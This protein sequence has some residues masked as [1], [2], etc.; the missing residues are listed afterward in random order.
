ML[1]RWKN[2]ELN[3]FLLA[4]KKRSK[5]I[6]LVELLAVNENDV[7]N[8]IRLQKCKD[9]NK[10]LEIWE[11]KL[12]EECFELRHPEHSA[13]LTQ[14]VYSIQFGMANFVIMLDKEKQ[15]PW[16]FAQC[17][18]MIDL[19]V[20]KE[21][22]YKTSKSN[23]NAIKPHIE[24]LASLYF[25]KNVHAKQYGFLLSQIRPY[26]YFYDH[27]KNY[28]A[29]PKNE[30]P[31]FGKKSFFYPKP[32]SRK[33][34]DEC[35]WLFPATVGGNQ[36]KAGAATYYNKRMEEYV[37]LSAVGTQPRKSRIDKSN[38]TL[39]YG[40]TGQKRQWLQ[41]EEAIANIAKELQPH[42]KKIE[43]LIDGMTAPEGNE[44][45]NL[46]DESVYHNIEKS[47]E[48][49][50]SVRSVIGL[51]YRQKIA[52][53]FKVD[54]FIANAGTGCIVPLRFC[55]KSGVLHSNS[56]LN[57]FPG[58]YSET[59][60]I[61]DKKYVKDVPDQDSPRPDLASYHIPWQHIFNL[62]AAVLNK[63]KGMTIPLVKVPKVEL[64]IEG[65][66]KSCKLN[67]KTLII[68]DEFEIIV[69]GE[70]TADTL[71]DAAIQQ[72]RQGNV[73]AALLIMLEAKKMRPKGPMINKKIEQYRSKI[74]LD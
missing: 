33:K 46:E 73:E 70:V 71:R 50:C 9:I 66:N 67:K 14:A 42:F 28:I 57:S 52:Q 16:L 38:L 3:R 45:E 23:V 65:E 15:S 44:I 8:I 30:K 21:N 7:S 18:G 53:C 55:K 62:L 22:F 17:E 69:S 35:V 37:A 27:L 74:L 1:S 12:K 47:I 6:Q 29:F 72:E 19:I 39:W 58:T 60:K 56:R 64:L 51:D 26:H 10:L 48:S 2:K 13:L 40:I 34:E 32:N 43:V 61:F 54:A 36:L 68:N 20:T 63:E 25:K 4:L 31:I 24:K 5:N 11:D 41:Q 49:I 59:V